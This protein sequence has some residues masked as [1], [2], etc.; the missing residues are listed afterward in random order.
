LPE[1]LRRFNCQTST[2]KPTLLT[3]FASGELPAMSSK[4][5][6][7]LGGG[8]IRVL[9]MWKM[10]HIREGREVQLDEC[11]AKAIGPLVWE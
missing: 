10:P 1:G 5:G 6:G 8:A 11:L 9:A 7:N 4:T 2:I 3:N